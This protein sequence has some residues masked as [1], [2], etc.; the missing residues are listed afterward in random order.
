MIINKV[1][2]SLSEQDTPAAKRPPPLG[3]LKCLPWWRHWRRL[4]SVPEHLT[5]LITTLS[6]LASPAQYHVSYTNTRYTWAAEIIGE[7]IIWSTKRKWEMFSFLLALFLF[8][9]HLYQI[10]KK[11][12]A[13]LWFKFY[14]TNKPEANLGEWISG[15]HYTFS[16]NEGC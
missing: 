5:P 6:A 16:P 13:F 1:I 12:V 14:V 4:I 7:N 11:G 3:Q 9:L 2:V 8:V 10:T 15:C